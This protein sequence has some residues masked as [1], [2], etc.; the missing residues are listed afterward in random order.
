MQNLLSKSKNSYHH[1]ADSEGGWTAVDDTINKVKEP[2]RKPLGVKEPVVDSMDP[3]DPA[4]DPQELSGLA[5]RL[6]GE[7][8]PAPEADVKQG[9]K[10]NNEIETTSGLRSMS[11]VLSGSRSGTRSRSGS[12]SG[13]RSGSVSSSSPEGSASEDESEGPHKS[14]DDDEDDDGSD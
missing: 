12:G 6:R 3:M 1:E 5:D 4:F 8:K 10:E 11:Y 14:S 9:Q 2:S 13:S 7:D